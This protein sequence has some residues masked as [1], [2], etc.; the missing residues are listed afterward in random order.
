M[1]SVFDFLRRRTCDAVVAGVCDAM[2]MLEN[3]TPEGAAPELTPTRPS[4]PAPP[5]EP[6]PTPPRGTN[7]GRPIS[8]PSGGQ[9]TPHRQVSLSPPNVSQ[10]DLLADLPHGQPPALPPRKRGRP[11]KLGPGGPRS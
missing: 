10:A 1:F 3:D 4:V 8:I 11:P 6:A 9:P 7:P 5:V 2:E